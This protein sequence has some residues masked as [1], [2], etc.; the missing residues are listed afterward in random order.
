MVKC[1]YLEHTSQEIQLFT[2]YSLTLKFLNFIQ[3]KSILVI[4]CWNS[5]MYPFYSNPLYLQSVFCFKTRQQQITLGFQYFSAYPNRGQKGESEVQKRSLLFCFQVVPVRWAQSVLQGLCIEAKHICE[6]HQTTK[7][8]KQ[9]KRNKTKPFKRAK[10]QPFL[11]GL[12]SGCS[13]QRYF[14]I[15]DMMSR[16]LKFDIEKIK[17]HFFPQS[18]CD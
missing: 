12:E 10:G 18:N 15:L 17:K 2:C 7:I 6:N 14:C 3:A 9:N 16:A 4:Y 11:I 13:L 1:A 8:T 5:K